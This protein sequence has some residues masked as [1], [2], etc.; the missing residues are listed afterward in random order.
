MANSLW[1]YARDMRGWPP[2]PA[3]HELGFYLRGEGVFPHAF[4]QLASRGTYGGI[5]AGSTCFWVDP[6]GE[7]TIV[8]CAGFP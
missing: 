4:R 6:D 7:L 1:D 3:N 8:E 2:I 5:G